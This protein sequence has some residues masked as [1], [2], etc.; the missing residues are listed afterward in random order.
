LFV[1]GPVPGHR[2]AHKHGIVIA[3]ACIAAAV[4][5]FSGIAH[6]GTIAGPATVRVAIDRSH[7][8]IPFSLEAS[9][10]PPGDGSVFMEQCDG[11]PA[12]DP[13][14]SPTRD[15][16]SASSPAAAS[17][18]ADGAVRF[19]ALDPNFGF[20][21][22]A[23]KSPQGLF[24][25]VAPGDALNNGKRTFTNCQVR[26]ATSLIVA[27]TDQ[28]FV[29]LVFPPGASGMAAETTPTKR[30]ASSR[31]GLVTGA[32]SSKTQRRVSSPQGAASNVAVATRPAHRARD[33]SVASKIRDA[34]FSLPGLV[35]LAVV[36][37]LGFELV[38]RV[39]RARGS[40]VRA[41]EHTAGNE[42]QSEHSMNDPRTHSKTHA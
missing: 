6:A 41:P 12:T 5:S 8:P 15:C 24:N 34:L 18:G 19:P 21:P 26:V 28:A 11:V 9:G 23:G 40:S 22:F 17:A 16:D 27:T 2:S 14:W 13:S 7:V 30:T 31:T 36:G 25:C 3:A 33:N 35:L 20:S 4:F 32:E 10:F 1:R 42:N 37:W 39:H 38:R 29:A